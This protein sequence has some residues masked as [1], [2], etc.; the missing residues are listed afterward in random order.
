MLAVVLVRIQPKEERRVSEVIQTLPQVRKAHLT[1]GEH[2]A[3]LLVEGET[4]G[5][6]ADFVYGTLRKIRGVDATEVELVQPFK[7]DGVAAQ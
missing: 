4:P 2:D 6:I 3:L 7:T 1:D 5:A